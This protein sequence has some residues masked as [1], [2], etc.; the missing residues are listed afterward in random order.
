MGGYGTYVWGAYA[1]TLACMAVEPVLV[2]L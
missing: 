2:V 1:V